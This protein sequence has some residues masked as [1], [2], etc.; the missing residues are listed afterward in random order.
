MKKTGLGVK[1]EAAALDYLKNKDYIV[2]AKNFISRFGEIDLIV[3]KDNYLCFVEVKTRGPGYIMKPC[4]S[5]TPAKQRKIIKTAEYFIAKNVKMFSDGN[6]Q[7][8]FDCIEVYVDS[9][10]RPIKINHIENAFQSIF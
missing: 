3:R 10:D 7:P 6:L 2:L 5:V 9:C 1:G 8:R 4:E